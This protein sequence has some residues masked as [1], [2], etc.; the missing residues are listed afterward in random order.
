MQKKCFRLY[1]SLSC[2]QR[3][4]IATV[5]TER[6]VFL[7]PRLVDQG[8]RCIRSSRTRRQA[9]TQ[10]LSKVDR[11]RTVSQR[12]KPSSCT[13]LISEQLNPWNRFQLRDKISRHRGARSWSRYELLSRVSLL[14][15]AYLLSCE[16]CL[17]SRKTAGRYGRRLRLGLTAKSCHQANILPLRSPT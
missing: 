17:T 11:D 14:S 1:F 15:P 6:R 9:L 2:C 5:A 10:Y 4:T 3:L 12:S 8:V 7:A 13:F 16:R